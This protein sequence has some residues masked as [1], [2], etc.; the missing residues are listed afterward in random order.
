M[1]THSDELRLAY[2]RYITE[3]RRMWSDMKE[4]DSR[5]RV[6]Y[7]LLVDRRAWTISAVSAA[8]GLTRITVRQVLGD[9]VERGSVVRANGG[10][11]I[12]DCGVKRFRARFDEF[13]QKVREPLFRFHRILGREYPGEGV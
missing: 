11:Q 13:F 6:S 8:S 2:L 12:T 1:N 7:C 9:Q 5:L 3:G 10:H 4:T